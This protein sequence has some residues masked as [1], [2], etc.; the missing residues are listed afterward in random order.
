MPFKT[1]ISYHEKHKTKLNKFRKIIELHDGMSNIFNNMIWLTINV[2]LHF[3]IHADYKVI[4]TVLPWTEKIAG[5][6][7]IG[8]G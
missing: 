7:M 2:N 8:K 4:F 6:M 3:I 5:P 1:S